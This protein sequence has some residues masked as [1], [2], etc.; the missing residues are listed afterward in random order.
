MKKQLTMVPLV[1]AILA[2]TGCQTALKS[3]KI[4]SVKTRVFG[5][6]VGT[7]PVN[8]TPT[9]KLGLVTTVIQMIPTSTNGTV[10]A[11]RFF[12]TFQIDSTS[13]PFRTG[14]SENTGAGDVQVTTNAQGS[15][16][17]PKAQIPQAPIKP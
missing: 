1:A 4:V 16:I 17:I 11:P 12:D 9:V 7:D 2:T 15:A 13:N 8:Q 6:V 3:D 5:V 14:I 10:N